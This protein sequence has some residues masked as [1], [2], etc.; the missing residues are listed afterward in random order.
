MNRKETLEKYKADTADKLQKGMKLLEADY[1]ET[2]GWLEEQ[3]FD[4][5]RKLSTRAEF[6]IGYI[7]FSLLRSLMDGDIY[8]LR[9]SV[10]G[11]DYFLDPHCVSDTIDVSRLFGSLR[12]VRRRIY[13]VA[14]NYRGKVE[15]FD[16]DKMIRETAM[17]LFK[18]KAERY[19][20]RFRD[21]DC[22]DFLRDLALCPRLI[23]KWGEHKEYSETVFLKDT[24]EKD[25]KQFLEVN[26]NNTIQQWNGSYV[27]Q[28]WENTK[29]ENLAVRQKNLLFFV[30]RDSH[31]ENCQWEGCLLHG[32]SFREAVLEK[33]VFAGCD[34]TACDFRKSRLH[35]V[36]FINCNLSETDFTGA[37]IDE[38]DFSGSL[39]ENT[40]FS[41]TALASSGLTTGQLQ[42]IH[43]EEEPYV[44]YHGTGQKNPQ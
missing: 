42:E 35:Q 27:Y 20:K 22:Q 7:Q 29:F 44:F 14:E 3:L 5:I 34:L 2:E 12:E 4:C 39:M 16:G 13:E 19:R 33:T 41:R 18:K 28:S 40:S 9:A 17:M 30:M 23:V 37:N 24:R 15:Q 36:R 21:F 26:K 10:Y 32:A 1:K 11:G 8:K 6:P 25:A 43:L 38:M 31:M